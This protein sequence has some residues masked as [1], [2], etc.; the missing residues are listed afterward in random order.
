MSD[1]ATL[2]WSSTGAPAPEGRFRS[3]FVPERLVGRSEVHG[4]IGA[5]RVEAR[6]PLE[7]SQGVLRPA[8]LQERHPQV[9][10]G[11]LE[12]RVDPERLPIVRLGVRVA[13]GLQVTIPQV[14]ADARGARRA[15]LQ[16]CLNLALARIR[17]TYA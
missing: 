8:Q 2:S 12:L 10:P 15:D 7:K 11:V 4:E 6:G 16:P 3:C 14:V 1:T 5:L 17:G 9:D 13:P